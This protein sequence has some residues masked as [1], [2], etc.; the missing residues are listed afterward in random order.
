MSLIHLN[1]SDFWSVH[2]DIKNC[3][4]PTK[5]YAFMR[6]ERGFAP[7][8]A[9]RSMEHLDDE[10]RVG[11]FLSKL[12]NEDPFNASPNYHTCGWILYQHEDCLFL[13]V[14]TWMISEPGN[15][16][17]WLYPYPLVRDTLLILQDIYPNLT[18]LTFL[19][20]A[21]FNANLGLD[22][23]DGVTEF[24]FKELVSQSVTVPSPDSDDGLD[25]IFPSPLWMFCHL[26]ILLNNKH[27]A[28]T[29]V[30]PNMGTLVDEENADELIEWFSKKGIN[31]DETR[32]ADIVKDLTEMI[33]QVDE[34]AL[35]Q[36]IMDTPRGMNDEAGMFG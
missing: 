15:Q 23:P 5:I 6:G 35:V 31:I 29:V 33:E 27:T 12:S 36:S 30:V 19:G 28:T 18:D 8:I 7:L 24:D 9:T 22:Q 16:S 14:S 3:D 10:N 32:H 21:G 13:E 20:S 11:F 34:N 26:W 4:T 17:G 2:D 1:D 25:V